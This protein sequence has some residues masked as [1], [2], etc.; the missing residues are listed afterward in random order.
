VNDQLITNA[1]HDAALNIL[2]NSGN[3]VTLLVK[4]YKAAAPF[5][6]GAK[7]NYLYYQ[8]VIYLSNCFIM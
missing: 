6:L 7:G 4:H 8:F 1:C 5:L 2:R 3:H